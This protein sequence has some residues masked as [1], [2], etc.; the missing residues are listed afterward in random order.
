MAN[1]VLVEVWRGGT[2]ESRHRGAAVI[3]DSQGAILASWGDGGALV[4]PR[5][6][7]KPLQAIPLVESGAAD[8]YTLSQREIALACASHTG[9]AAH[10]TAVAAW[11]ARVGLGEADL[12]CGPQ[13]PLGEAAAHALHRAGTAPSRLHNNCS[14]KHAGFLTAALYLGLPTRGYGQPSHPLQEQV[15]RILAEM[16]GVDGPLDVLAGD[17]CGVPTVAMPLHT[18]A[19]S[20]AT[21][22]DPQGQPEPRRESIR[23][24]MAA[25]T[26]QPW[27]VSGTGR[28]DTLVIES[29]RGALIVKGGAEG[30][31][32][33]ALPGRGLGI[34]LKI[35]DGAKR[36][37]EV[38]MAAVL[39][40]F[41]P[42]GGA[43]AGLLADL[44]AMPIQDTRCQRVGVV[45]PAAGW[46]G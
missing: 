42:E 22:A 4:F 33:A 1:P 8:R 37:A 28:F 17:G 3:V 19:R 15:R 30:V 21:L 31:C 6:T 44:A 39:A 16:G 46:P 11:L 38:A 24:I 20:F 36:A 9:E 35:D 45:R 18:L 23:R 5:S 12:V 34:A 32:A 14:G 27:F 40:R 41:L 13:I 25:M 10:V 7:V 2:V 29:G 43:L 26:A